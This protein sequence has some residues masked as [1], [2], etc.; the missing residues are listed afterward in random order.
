LV[1]DFGPQGSYLISSK[2]NLGL[3]EAV[4]SL[5]ETFRARL[6]INEDSVVF[7]GSSKGGASALYF[8]HRLGYGHAV[9]GAPQTKIGHFLHRQ[10]AL[11]GPRLSAYMFPAADAEDRLDRLIY[12]LPVG[13]RVRRH[14]HVGRGDHHYK[15]HVLP[16][17]Q[18]VAAHGGEIAL[19]VGDYATHKEVGI[20]FPAFI[21]K[22]FLGIFGLS[23]GR[24]ESAA[25]VS[26]SLSLEPQGH[27]IE[28]VCSGQERGSTH[29]HYLYRN[30]EVIQK[31]PYT[32]EK[33]RHISITGNGIYYVRVFIKTPGG[34]TT[35]I[36]TNQI[37]V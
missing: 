24:R 32:A 30:G 7:L 4:C 25:A 16:Y 6:G 14:I 3:A 26:A 22:T 8:A 5:I 31:L 28:V 23:P 18:H 20:H 15:S 10:D 29:A 36:N 34:K 35:I 9:V 27:S 11:N 19:D 2:G 13:N 21:E 12:D 37:V 17:V 33:L 1:D